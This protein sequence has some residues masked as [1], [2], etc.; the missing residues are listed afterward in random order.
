[1]VALVVSNQEDTFYYFINN[2]KCNQEDYQKEPEI[3]VTKRNP[4][5]AIIN[6]KNRILELALFEL[7]QDVE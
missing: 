7:Y 3:E 6:L 1:M 2:R 5:E 4:Q